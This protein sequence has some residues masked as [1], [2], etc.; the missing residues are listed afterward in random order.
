L[1]L[2]LTNTSGKTIT[3]LVLNLHFSDVNRNGRTALHQIFLGI[4]RDGKFT[5]PELRFAANDALEIPLAPRYAEIN[6][7]LQTR[8][9]DRLFRE[10]GEFHSALFADGT[11]FEAGTFYHRNP[12]RNEP[13]KWI[14]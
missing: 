6:N 7:L 8:G 13:R 1:T 10:S 12:D 9:T 3:Y 2:K 5:R 14:P 4:D 11:L